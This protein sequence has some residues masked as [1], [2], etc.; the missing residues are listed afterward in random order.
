VGD[1]DILVDRRYDVD[2]VA[3]AL[4]DL[5]CVTAPQWLTSARQYFACYV[6]DGV[7]FSDSTVEVSNNENRWECQGPGPWQ[8]HVTVDCAGHRIEC[9][10][11]ELRLTTEFLRNR[12]D[13]YTPLL[14]HL[15]AHGANLDLLQESMTVRRVP[16][17]LARLTRGLQ[18][19]GK[20]QM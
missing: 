15:G 7:G 3:E 9:V 5:R 17:T 13:R 20:P 14:A 12:P 19:T 18:S 10:R 1:V 11:L 16:E 4:A 6:L 2:A 8:H